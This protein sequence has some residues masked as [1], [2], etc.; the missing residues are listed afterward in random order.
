MSLLL[1]I[2]RFFLGVLGLIV[3]IG[4]VLIADGNGWKIAQ[5]VIWLIIGSGWL[6][7]G[8]AYLIERYKAK[9]SKDMGEK[10]G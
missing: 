4:N 9:K 6:F 7:T 2:I 8:I 10:N 1:I 5:G 3:G